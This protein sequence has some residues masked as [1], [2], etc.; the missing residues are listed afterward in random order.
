M[1]TSCVN[2]NLAIQ[3]K[4]LKYQHHCFITCSTT[5]INFVC[6][7]YE[8]DETY[9]ITYSTDDITSYL[10]KLPKKLIKFSNTYYSSNLLF[11]NDNECYNLIT[12]INK[13]LLLDESKI[14]FKELLFNPDDRIEFIKSKLLDLYNGMIKYP[15]LL[16]HQKCFLLNI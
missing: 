8:T 12:F 6:G 5:G 11:I 3:L 14:I 15:E 10:V 16:P 4:D 2:L 1:S 9:N 7:F 13:H